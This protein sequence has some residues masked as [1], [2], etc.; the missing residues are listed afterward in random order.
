VIHLEAVH[1]QLLLGS[2]GPQRAH[3][4]TGVVCGDVEA[5]RKIEGNIQLN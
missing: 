1:I 4:D 2:H 5:V 3:T